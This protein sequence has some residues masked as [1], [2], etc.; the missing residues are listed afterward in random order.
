MDRNRS[1][2]LLLALCQAAFISTAALMATI[3]TLAGHAVAG[4]V[5]RA[6]SAARA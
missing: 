2:V 5:A 1:N 4:S 3:G 6:L